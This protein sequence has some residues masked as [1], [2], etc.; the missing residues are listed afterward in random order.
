MFTFVNEKILLII[1]SSNVSM[2]TLFVSLSILLLSGSLLAKDP[3]LM[4]ING[5]PVSKS[6]FEY[7]YNK[8]NSNNVLDKKTLEE[9]VDLFVNFKLKV[10]EAKTQGIDTTEA[11]INELKGY[12]DQLTRPYLTDTKAEEDALKEA[13]ERLKEDVEVSHILIRVDQHAA[14]KIR[15]QRGIRSGRYPKIAA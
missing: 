6:E 4:T 7:I 10:E 8:N 11:F 5:N 12:R 9:Y 13:Y 15:W 14:P 3:V 1:C 2:R